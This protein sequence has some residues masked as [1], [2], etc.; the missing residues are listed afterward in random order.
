[1]PSA[2]STYRLAGKD[3]WAAVRIVKRNPNMVAGLIITLIMG[4]MAITAPLISREDPMALNTRQRLEPP[5]AQN[6]FGKDHFGRD[7]Y[8]RAIFGSRLSLI[9]GGS[10]SII[11]L[12]AGT[13]IGLVAGYFRKLDTPVMRVMDGLMSIP[14]ILLAIALMALLGAS[15]QNVII[16]L[17]VT[18]TPAVSR[19]ARS[20][21]LSLR[22]QPFVESATAIGASSLRIILRHILPNAMAPLIVQG[23]F[24][25]ASSMLV[26][27][28]LSFLGA[29]LPPDIPSWGNMIADGRQFLRQAV[30]I[31]A[32]PGVFLTL[33]VLG[34]NLVGD[35][36]GDIVDPRLARRM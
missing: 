29:G 10:V 32:F 30:W 18:Y 6:W 11:T 19:L 34:V 2:A 23:T 24:I 4:L 21:V 36:L 20:S 16:A 13:V 35:G 9:V 15:L 25:V 3:I 7:V 17:S 14:G 5:S 1:M 12:L 8:A 27:A 33:T 22:N 26:E 28:A 31:I